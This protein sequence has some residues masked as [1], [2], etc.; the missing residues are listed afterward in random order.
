MG[1]LAGPKKPIVPALIE[2]TT[3]AIIP[4]ASTTITLAQLQNS[5]L[6]T[7]FKLETSADLDVSGST[8]I[9]SSNLLACACVC[10]FDVGMANRVYFF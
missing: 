8:A 5:Q 7:D 4:P 2:C 3:A 6:K 9:S 10:R 1:S